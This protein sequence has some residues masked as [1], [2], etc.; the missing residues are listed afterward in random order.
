MNHPSNEAVRKEAEERV[1]RAKR[2]AVIFPHLI[3]EPDLKYQ[4]VDWQ[5]DYLRRMY[6]L[7]VLTRKVVN[8]EGEKVNKVEV[9]V[10]SRKEYMR[11]YMAKKRAMKRGE[12]PVET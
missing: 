8:I 7:P 5:E 11:K 4:D 6:K 10:N 3:R 2:Y 1:E 12:I 9:D